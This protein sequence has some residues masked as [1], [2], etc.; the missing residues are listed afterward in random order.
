MLTGCTRSVQALY[1]ICTWPYTSRERAFSA[2]LLLHSAFILQPF[3]H[4][5]VAFPTLSPRIQHAIPPQ[6]PRIQPA[7]NTLSPTLSPAPGRPGPI[8]SLIP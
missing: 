4:F 8:A 2:G 5:G 6:S 1:S 7:F 3:P